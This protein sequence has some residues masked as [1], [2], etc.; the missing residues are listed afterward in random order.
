MNSPHEAHEDSG[1]LQ[2]RFQKVLGGIVLYLQARQQLFLIE[3]KDAV[4]FLSKRLVLAFIAFLFIAF[5]YALFLGGAIVVID[6]FTRV[7]WW[8]VCLLLAPVHLVIG[9]IFVRLCKRPPSVRLFDDSIRELEKDREWL[10]NS[11]NP[12]P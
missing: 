12:T 3:A 4:H 11:K 5:G 7:P 6:R 10:S 2:A 8:F 1:S 9:Y